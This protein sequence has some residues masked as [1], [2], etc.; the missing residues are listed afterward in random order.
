[1]TERE[2]GTQASRQTWL[3]YGPDTHSFPSFTQWPV[4]H[5]CSSAYGEG[6]FFS[7]MVGVYAGGKY[8]QV[9]S[10]VDQAKFL[11]SCSSASCGHCGCAA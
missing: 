5:Q 4:D 3:H 6:F 10:D 9:N 2:R 11:P 8:C 1:M 7:P